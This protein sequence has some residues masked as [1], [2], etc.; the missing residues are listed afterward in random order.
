MST[1]L[2]VNTHSRATSARTESFEVEISIE[3]LKRHKSPGTEQT[4][5]EWIKVGGRIIRSEIHKLINSVSKEDE[6]PVE[7]KEPIILPV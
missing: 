2:Y 4:P 3:K 6:L 7:C 1:F 5:A